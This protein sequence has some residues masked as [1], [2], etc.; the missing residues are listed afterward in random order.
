MIEVYEEADDWRRLLERAT[1]EIL[2]QELD[3]SREVHPLAIARPRAAEQS[4]GRRNW[5]TGGR[6]R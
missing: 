3:I 2:A 6:R 5:D 1:A 4:R